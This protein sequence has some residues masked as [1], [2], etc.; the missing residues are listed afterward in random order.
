MPASPHLS[1]MNV[2]CEFHSTC[3]FR[4]IIGV[5]IERASVTRAALNLSES[6][7]RTMVDVMLFIQR[8]VVVDH[9]AVS[10]EAFVFLCPRSSCFLAHRLDNKVF[11][12]ANKLNWK[13]LDEALRTRAELVAKA[14]RL[15]RREGFH[16][17]FEVSAEEINAHRERPL[18]HVSSSTWCISV[19]LNAYIP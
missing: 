11:D 5:L 4:R 2:E 16:V 6:Q 17:S 1:R 12:H 10:L 14:K 19:R 9:G 13:L 7:I 8:E 3:L 18:E 15:N